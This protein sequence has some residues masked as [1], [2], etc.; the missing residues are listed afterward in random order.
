[1]TSTRL[2]HICARIAVVLATIFIL[3]V[4]SGQ[5][6]SLIAQKKSD[7]VII[8]PFPS[9]LASCLITTSFFLYPSSSPSTVPFFKH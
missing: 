9:A 8:T 6:D 4:V 5:F 7:I 2:E 1:M 3:A